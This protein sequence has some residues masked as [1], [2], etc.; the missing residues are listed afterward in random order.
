MERVRIY[1]CITIF[2]IGIMVTGCSSE[3]ISNPPVRINYV[4]TMSPD[5][6]KFVCPE[7]TY[8]DT[9]GEIHTISGVQELDSM[10]Y[11]NFGNSVWTIQPIE[12]TNYRAWSLCMT[13][14]DSPFF[15]YISVKYK[16]L[17]LVEDLTDMN[18]EFHH[19]IFSNA[20]YSSSKIGESTFVENHLSYIKSITC[21][22][23]EV[24]S[25]INNLINKPDKAGYYI[26]ED[27]Q[28]S[29]Y[30]DFDL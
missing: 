10:A 14:K 26:N 16:K 17:E 30:K 27:R 15:S 2:I 5:L 21:S 23:Q 13:F 9:Q 6:L 11:V 12:G 25:Y 18:Y 1:L 3:M 29:E 4:L 7:V 20:V 28:F 22:G 19:G 8:V 24:E